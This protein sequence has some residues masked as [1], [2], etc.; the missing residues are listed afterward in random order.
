M[1]NHPSLFDNGTGVV[2]GPHQTY[3]GWYLIKLGNKVYEY[4]ACGSVKLNKGDKVEVIII[5]EGVVE[6][7][8]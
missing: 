4:Q 7:I 5:D 1:A 3:E 8:G 2:V 6:V